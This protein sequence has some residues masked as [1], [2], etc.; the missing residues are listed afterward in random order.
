M[1]SSPHTRSTGLPGAQ[2]DAALLIV[3]GSPGGFEAGFEPAA[4]GSAAG[5]GQTRE[6]AQVGAAGTA[7]GRGSWAACWA[8]ATVPQRHAAEAECMQR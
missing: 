6:H 2:A 3:D 5:G 8:Q 4:P 1:S 7:C